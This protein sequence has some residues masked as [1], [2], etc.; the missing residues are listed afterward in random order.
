MVLDLFLGL[1]LVVWTRFGLIVLKLIIGTSS[2]NNELESAD[3]GQSAHGVE[4]MRKSDS[5][6]ES[7][8][9]EL[10]S[11]AGEA[12]ELK[13]TLED[14]LNLFLGCFLFLIFDLENEGRAENIL[15]G[16]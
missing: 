14:S 12:D 13:K 8:D 15:L 2:V 4:I 16:K 3:A 9:N 11:E 1:R 6:E 7:F 5:A 10:T